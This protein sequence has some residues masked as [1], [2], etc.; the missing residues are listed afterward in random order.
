[1]RRRAA[2]AAIGLQ[3]LALAAGSLPAIAGAEEAETKRTAVSVTADFVLGGQTD[4]IYFGN[5][6]QSDVTGTEKEPILWNV[7]EAEEGK[8]FLLSEKALDAMAYQTPHANAVSWE[9][10]SLRTWLNAQNGFLGTAFTEEE[11]G[12]LLA[13]EITY[14]AS[15]QGDEKNTCTDL[16]TALSF[17]EARNE[18]YGFSKKA[19]SSDEARAATATAYAAGKLGY[20]EGISVK[21]WLRSLGTNIMNASFADE[22][23][24]LGDY[25]SSYL[26][27]ADTS[28][29][30]RPA[31]SLDME[32]ILYLSALPET[33]SADFSETFLLDTAEGAVWTVTMADGSTGFAAEAL[34][35][36]H[37]VSVSVTEIGDGTYTQIT[38]LL[39]DGDGTV[40]CAGRAAEAGTG[41]FELALPETLPTGTYTLRLFAENV[42]DAA[43]TAGNSLDFEIVLS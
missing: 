4:Q 37:S 7:L 17:A 12:A 10:S 27:A 2:A 8:L 23:G 6:A 1:M 3:L 30:V 40:C 20:E 43:D 24:K 41:A 26:D 18:D 39:L 36:E 15:A 35:E 14:D 5:Y 38:A 33:R 16:V 28:T 29:A 11:Q 9:T 32:K 31:C 13:E 25:Q 22:N 34:Q 19:V 42:T 21:W